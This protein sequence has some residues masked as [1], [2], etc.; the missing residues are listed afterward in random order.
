MANLRPT[1]HSGR[2]RPTIESGYDV[3]VNVIPHGRGPS[4]SNTK[5][6]P[7]PAASRASRMAATP[8]W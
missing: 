4:S 7:I 2:A 1:E 5:E 8:A 6:K 3:G